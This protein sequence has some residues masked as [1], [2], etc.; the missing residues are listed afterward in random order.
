MA[1][2]LPQPGVLTTPGMIHRHRAL[3]QRMNGVLF[4]IHMAVLKWGVPDWQWIECGF[5]LF[6]QMIRRLPVAMAFGGQLKAAHRLDI[7]LKKIGLGAVIQAHLDRP[8]LIFIVPRF[9]VMCP[10]RYMF[11]KKAAVFDI[12]VQLVFVDVTAAAI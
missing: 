4:G 9:I 11:D 10:V 1:V 7:E 6:S 5:N 2:D 12:A 3:G 8:I